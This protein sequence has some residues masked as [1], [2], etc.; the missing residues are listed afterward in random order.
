M[1]KYLLIALSAVLVLSVGCSSS[2]EFVKSPVDELIRQ[3]DG[4]NNFTIILYD[5]DVDGTFSSTYKHRYKVI[6]E[7]ANGT[8]VDSLTEWV[9]VPEKIFTLHENDM[10]ME[11]ASKTDGK[12]SKGVS[13]PGYSNYVGNERYGQWRS[14]SNGTSFW[15][16]YGQYA[17][18]SS[19][20]GLM[21]GPVYRGS[22]YDYH[23]NYRGVR[24]YYGG[25]DS[26][27]LP[28]YGTGSAAAGQMNPDFANRSATKPAL[29]DRVANRVQRSNTTTTAGQRSTTTTRSDGRSST[30]TRSRSTS[31]GGK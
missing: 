14:D 25:T 4:Q 24:P 30:P 27:G 10:G 26:R 8:P 18:M 2:Q 12:L 28:M 29:R 20:I 7:D 21:A 13:P 3:L 17:F 22:Y 5:M 9:E 16:F 1:K 11:I 19:M 15:E 31:R 23:N 6:K